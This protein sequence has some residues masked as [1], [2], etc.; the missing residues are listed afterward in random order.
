[1]LPMLQG[2]AADPSSPNYQL[3]N[4]LVALNHTILAGAL[5][6]HVLFG[7]VLGFCG[8]LATSSGEVLE[9]RR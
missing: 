4:N 3:A 6:I 8:R 2:I 5:A 7:G 1:M 9:S